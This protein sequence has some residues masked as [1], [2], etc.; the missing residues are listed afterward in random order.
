MSFSKNSAAQ[1]M[2]QVFS[3]KHILAHALLKKQLKY[4]QLKQLVL[5][6]K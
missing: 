1:D 6:Y 3:I 5:S 2:T 4:Y